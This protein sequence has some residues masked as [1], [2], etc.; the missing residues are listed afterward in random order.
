MKPITEGHLEGRELYG[1]D[2]CP[3]ELREWFD[4]ER[5]GYY[6]LVAER[7]D[8]EYEYDRLNRKY[9]F[10]HVHER[11]FEVC[12]AIGCADGSDVLP[13]AKQVS[14]FIALEPATEWWRGEIGGRPARF[15]EPSETGHI[16]LDDGT[17]D[18]VTCFG[19]L[20]HIPNVSFVMSE[21][22]RVMCPGAI[23]LLREPLSSMGDFRQ[24]RQGCTRYERGIPVDILQSMLRQN[25]LTEIS[26]AK[27]MF[28]PLGKIWDR[29][30]GSS[31][32]AS[33]LG[34]AMDDLCCRLFAWNVRYRRNSLLRKFAPASA[35]IVAKKGVT[36]PP[37]FPPRMIR[38]RP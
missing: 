4:E 20:H 21:I 28:P 17:V 33:P 12:L 31:A 16:A 23:L 1:D 15:M 18:L 2:F 8:F 14:R 36:C 27:V 30:V 7:T 13:L 10:S 38:V 24:P 5:K 22:A 3:D 9:G 37:D 6:N 29:L 32:I 35:F 25:D 19:V 26:L 11:K 34:L